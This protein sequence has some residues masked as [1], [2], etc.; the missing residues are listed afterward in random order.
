M[1]R[2]ESTATL[3]DFSEFRRDP[4]TLLC[5]G[6]LAYMGYIFVSPAVF[7]PRLRDELDLGYSLTAAHIAA[8]AAGSM[9]MS[10]LLPRLERKFRRRTLIWSGV[11]GSACGELL[12]A[13][14]HHVVV[15]IGA[16]AIVGIAC[17]P[18]VGL[19]QAVL[20]D[21]HGES[22]AVALSEANTMGA[23]GSVL[24]PLV[25]GGAA[26]LL[27]AIGWRGG[28]VFG[29]LIGLA[30]PVAFSR[31]ALPDGGT[32]GKVRAARLP[33]SVRLRSGLLFATVIAEMCTTFL[34]PTYLRD[35]AHFSQGTTAA[36][37]GVFLC[38]IVAGRAIGSVLTRR[39]QPTQLL[40]RALLVTS[41][42]FVM[43]WS[44]TGRLTVALGYVIVGLGVANMFPLNVSLVIAA[45]PDRSGQAVSACILISSSAGLLGPLVLGALADVTNIRAAF[46]VVPIALGASALLLTAVSRQR[47]DTC[48]MAKP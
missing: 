6:L 30:L 41:F 2:P 46:V 29:A 47:H 23:S 43:L 8:S 42:G 21:R 17:T 20:A 18:I 40:A 45:A 37:S 5:Y 36:L 14:A 26:A 22:R 34:G 27:P 24:A 13:S 4:L 31:W 9:I 3:V 35:T 25:I 48:A 32:L 38:A 7:L 1:T 15:S 16:M 39:L 28:L 10:A 44:T 11:V 19:T 33:A 12:L